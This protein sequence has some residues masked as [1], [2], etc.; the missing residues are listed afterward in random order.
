LDRLLT[1]A[2][3]PAPAPQRWAVPLACTDK[4]SGINAGGNGT[5][6]IIAAIEAGVGEYRTP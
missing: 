4:S 2:I 5:S 6:Q 1:L 3:S